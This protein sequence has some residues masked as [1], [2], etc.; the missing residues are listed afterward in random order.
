MDLQQI[1]D[2]VADVL[3]ATIE[4]LVK[5]VAIDSISSSAEHEHKV[6]ES[7]EEVARLLREAGAQGAEIVEAGGKPA[8]IAHFPAPEG[9]PTVCLYAHHDVQ[10]TGDPDQWTSE[11]FEAT[12]RDGRLF[13]RG[14]A[15]DKGGFAAHLAALRAFGG[16]P[17]VG[18]T[19][20]IEGEEEIGS[21]SLRALIEQHSDALRADVFVIL[22]SGNWEVGTPALTTTLR[23]LADC[24]VE[25]RTLDHALHSGMY[26]GVVPDALTTLCRLLATLHDAEGNVAVEGLHS[27]TAADLDYPED[28]LRA[29]TGLL[30]G[31]EWI[32][33]GS[34]VDRMWT[35]PAVSV[36]AI[37]APAVADASNTLLPVARAKVSLR[38]APGDDADRALQCLRKHLETHAPW[39]AQVSVVDGET[40]QPGIVSVE[41]AICEKAI[42]A[43]GQAFGTEPV[44]IGMGGSIPMIADFQSAFPDAVVLVTAVGD[45]DSRQHG[46]D[47][48]L[49][50]GDFAKA[51]TA[52]AL[53]LA[54]LA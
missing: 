35:K 43:I 2:A 14:T 30:E 18:V 44:Q 48:S 36:L 21:P 11:P 50:L 8:V 22:D 4:D 41:G 16:K 10:P 33:D 13:G 37:D 46:I 6:R 34:A 12:E 19:L 7:A 54:K 32:G 39:G 28:R 51:A 53:L 42:E 20:F 26:G 27:A 17:P 52:E 24:T 38:V 1:K 31:V 45:P 25:V 49:H 3:P 15:D 40:G 47:E 9:K 23:G 5:L 29:E